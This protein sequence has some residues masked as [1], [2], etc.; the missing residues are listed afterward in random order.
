MTARR[1]TFH[2]SIHAA[3]VILGVALLTALGS[4]QAVRAQGGPTPVRVAPVQVRE[5]VPRQRVTGEVR[6]AW[7]SVIAS[8]ESGRVEEV[9]VD[10]GDHVAEGDPLV[11]LDAARLEIARDRTRARRAT[12]GFVI[13]V[14][15]RDLEQAAR[16]RD[17]LQSL[18]GDRATNPKELADAETAVLAAR[19]RLDEARSLAAEID[20]D[21]AL[22]DR[23]LDDTTVR[24]PADAIVVRR[25]T[26]LGRWVEEGGDV[27][28]L[29]ADG[30]YEVWLDVPQRLASALARNAEGAGGVIA[31]VEA[32]GVTTGPARPIVVPDLDRA[33]RTL[34]A[35][36]RVRDDEGRL[37]SGMSAI[38]WVPSGPAARHVLVPRDA[39][40]RGEAG[41]FVYSV[42]AGG[43]SAEAAMPVPVRILFQTDGF[44]AVRAAGGLDAGELVVVEG[45]ER[46]FPMMPVRYEP[47]PPVDGG[48]PDA[49]AGDGTRE[50]SG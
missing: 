10:E 40:N 5:V 49:N 14:R 37:A 15:E 24:A 43:E 2:R 6:A 7:R 41:F 4:G 1:R 31:E 50:G 20:A 18:S 38:G 48:A 26:D 30:R 21:L 25:L 3:R 23:R 16:D 17:T 47:P 19:A 11:R 22:L 8:L 27:V 44:T 12:A 45:N 33:S 29:V 46:L 13:Q 35:Y 39:V 9:L 34:Q 42:R 32:A 28:E 36:L